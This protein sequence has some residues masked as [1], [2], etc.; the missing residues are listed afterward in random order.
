MGIYTKKKSFYRSPEYQNDLIDVYSSRLLKNIITK[1]NQVEFFA[2]MAD[3]TKDT[4]ETKS[5]QLAIL[6]RYVDAEGTKI[7]ERAIGLH[8]LKDCGAESIANAIQSMLSDKRLDIENC[9]GQCYDGA[10]VISGVQAR[11][12]NLAPHATY[13]HCEA[14]RLNLVVVDVL[15]NID[16]VRLF[17]TV[18]TLSIHFQHCYSPSAFCKNTTEDE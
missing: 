9:V 3:E 2:I 10:N 1:G 18:Q 6:I 12:K 15:G 8:H 7:Y 14:D 5:E 13:F 17:S 11:I 16:K 4:A